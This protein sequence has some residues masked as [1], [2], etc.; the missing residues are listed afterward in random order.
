M[1]RNRVVNT[2][3][4]SDNY[5]SEL[6]PV[7]KLLFLYLIT[8]EKTNIAGIYEIPLKI[9]AVETGIEKE[10]I[11]KILK[12]FEKD[13]KVYYKHGY[14]FLVNFIFH[15]TTN[16]SVILGI[17]R[18]I[19]S[20]PNNILKFCI[21]VW[22]ETGDSLAHLTLLNLTLPNLTLP[23]LTEEPTNVDFLDQLINLFSNEYE[24]TK[25][26]PYK[27]AGKDRAAIGGLLNYYK[28]QN[29]D[30]DTPKTLEHFGLLFRHILSFDFKNNFL[31]QITLSKLNS[32]FN[33][34]RQAV[35]QTNKS[36]FNPSVN[37][38]WANSD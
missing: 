31:N 1:A 15:Q 37:F 32:N 2:K 4:W 16:P 6:D 38:G 8:N 34:Y 36:G 5:V 22:G 30:S 28:Q 27:K 17:Q 10:M 14:V 23:N 12:R 33:E 9:I 18:E 24:L 25:K 7:E 29:P 3:F 35:K 26:I 11:Q 21:T 13:K 19:N 20:L